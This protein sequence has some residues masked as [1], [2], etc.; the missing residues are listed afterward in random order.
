MHDGRG[1]ERTAA[2]GDASSANSNAGPPL[3]SAPSISLPKGGGAIRGIGEKFAA[4]PVTGTGSMTVPIAVTPGRSGF[5]PQ[6]TIS[7]DSGLGNGPLGFG[8]DLSLPA[9]TR[10][11]DKGLPKYHD[12]D[13][14]DTFI[15]TG[16]EDL[17]PLLIK[18]GNKWRPSLFERAVGSVIYRITRYCPRVEGLFARIEQWT[19]VE[20]GDTHWR[21]ISKE[22]ITT[23]YGKTPESR[24]ADPDDPARVFS[25]LICESRDDKGN[26]IVY[27]YV[28]EDSNNIDLAQ[29][30]ERNRTQ[31]SRSANRYLKRIK[32][33]NRVSLL[34][35]PDLSQAV[36][37]FEVVFD[38]DEGHYDAL[39]RRTNAQEF[40]RANI[41]STRNWS[42]RRDPFSTFRAGFEVRTYRLCRRALMFHHFSEELGVE[43]YLV[44]STEFH[45]AE[46]PIASFLTSVTQSGYVRHED[47]AYLIRSLPPLEFKYSEAVIQDEIRQVD[48][49]S[50]ENLPYGLESARYQWVDLDGEGVSGILTQQADEWFYKPNIG[51]GRFGPAQLV[52]LKPS[53]ADLN[54]AQQ[55]MDLD[56][57]GQL[58]L[59]QL[60]ASMS[61]FYERTPEGG[62][63]DFTPF[64]STPNLDWRDS[65][66]RFIDLTGDGNADILISG[67]KIFTWHPSLKEEGFGQGKRTHQSFDEEQGPRLVFADPAQSI[68]L[69]D[70]SGDGLTDLVRVRN[71]EV[72]YWPNLGYG[73]FGARI[74]MDDS[75]WLDAPGL[76]DQRRIRLA[77]IDGS[78]VTDIVYL[79]TDGVQIYFNQSGNGWTEQRML[80]QFPRIDNLSTVTIVDL[81][82]NGTACL[83]WSSP[84]PGDVRRPMHYIDLMGG[85]KPHLMV[86][87]KNNLGAETR[88]HYVAST[89][90][91][92]AD[93]A[94]GKPW[95]TKLPFPVHVV[96]RVETLDQI[97]RNRFVTR[98]AYHHGFFDG[99]EREFRGFGMV[100]QKDTE[101][102]ASLSAGDN[103]LNATNVDAASHVPPVLTKTWFHTGVWMEGTR[104]L[105]QFEREYYREPGLSYAELDALLLPDTILPDGLSMQEKREACRALRGS[106]LRQEIYALDGA[107]H[108]AHPHV[109]SERNYTIERLQPLADNR[110]A[111][112]FTHQ[113]ETIDYHYER[114]P[115]DPRTSHA[116]TL[117]VDAFGN[118][119][120]SAAVGYGRRHPDS[121]LAPQ[122]QVKQAQTLVTCAENKFT[123]AVEQDDDYRA[124]LPSER[125]TF[126]LTGLKSDSSVRFDFGIIDDAALSA[127]QIDYE[128]KPSDGL[129]KRLIEHIRTLY[130]RSDLDGPLPLG[131]L[132]SLA[133]PFESYRL[134]FTPGLLRQVYEECVTEEM[135]ASEGRYVHSEGDDNWWIPSGRAFFTL[136][137]TAPPAQ[138]LDDAR[139]HFFLPRLFLD[140]F[141]SATTVSYDTYDLLLTETRDA[142]G[143][144]VRSENDYRVMQPRLITDPNGN[145]AAVA[146]DALG[147]VVGTAVMGKENENLGDS[148]DGFDAD[149]DEATVKAHLQDP[150]ADP[151]DILKRAS[152]RLVYDLHL[153]QRTGSASN[154]QPSVVYT[155]A[156]ETHDADLQPGEQTKV[157]HSFS[158]S[159]GFGREI[160][161]KIQAEPGPVVEGEPE[162]APRWVGSGWTIFNNK[163]KPV[164]QYE[165]FFSAT[166]Q[167]EFARRV[168]VSSI[169]FYD[170][171]ERV[172]GTLHPN[173]TWEK[174][175]FDPWRQEMWDVNDT[176][177]VADPKSDPDVGDFFSHLPDPDFL[178]T[179]YAQRK[180]GA[181]G[182]LE[183]AA[184]RKA[185]V[186]ANSP[187]V[188]HADAL[189]RT[190]LTVVHNKFKYNDAH[191][192][193]PP[194]EEF[195]CTRVLLDIENNEREVIDAKDR[196]VM[197]YDYDLLGNR[198]H[199]ASMEAGERWMLNDVAGKPIHAWD[200]RN[201]QF[202]TTYDQLRRPID[203]LLR[204][205]SGDELLVGRSV[206]GESRPDPEASNLR[207]KVVQVFDQ[208]GVITSDEYDFKGNLLHG[209]RQLASDYKTVLDWS[210][211]VPLE[212]D[213]YTSRTRYDA[214][215]RPTEMTTPDK[216]V[217]RPGYN[218]ANLLERVEAN[219]RGEQDKGEPVWTPFV[220]DIDYDAKGQRTLIDYGNG[221]RITYAYDPLTFRLV[222]LLTR[223][224]AEAFPDDCPQPPP[225]NWPGCQVQNLHY[226]Y[227]PV[228]NITN[229]RDDA[230]QTVFF[231]NKRVEPSADYTYDALNRLIEATGREHLGQV[232]AAVSP[233]SYN[234]K[235]RVGILFS[236]S[237]G[238]AM[239]RYLERYVYDEV[240]NFKEMIHRGSDP[241]NAGWTRAYEYDEPSLLEPAKQGNRLTGTIVGATT[242]TYSVGGNGY[243]AHGNMLRMP[244]LQIMQWDFK[245]QLQM[246][247]RQAVNA[248]EEE[249]ARRQGERTWY[250]Y[251]ANGQRVRKV[252]ESAAGQIKDERIYLGGFEIYR[253]PGA[254]AL[255]RETL[256]IMDDRQRIAIVETRT[257]GNDDLPARLIRFQF[258]NH[259][260]SA[261]LEL[262]EHAQIISYEE[263]TP[264]GSTGYQAVRSQ[265][266]TP[267]RY[268][269]TGKERDEES[270]Y[271]YIGARYYCPWL[272]RWTRP[273]PAGTQDGPC[274]YAYVQNNPVRRVDPDGR[275]GYDTQE[276]MRGMMWER[277]SREIS[278]IITGMFGGSADVDV[279][280]NRVEYSGP[281]GGV[282][283]VVGGVVRA[284]TLRMV[285]IEDH[286]TMT[287]LMGLEVGAGLVPVLDP[288]ARL[289]TGESVTGQETS[290][291]WAAAQLALDVAPFLWELH[292]ARIEARILA[293]EGR[294]TSVSLAF[295]PGAPGHNRVGVNTGEGTQWSHLVVDNSRESL[296]VIKGG[297]AF[298]EIP[299]TPLGSKYTVVEIPVSPDS[300]ARAMANAQAQV[301]AGE[302]GAYGLLSNDCSTYASNILQSG[303]VRMPPVSTPALNYAAVALRSPALVGPLHVAAAVGPVASAGLRTTYLEEQ[304]QASIPEEHAACEMSEEDLLRVCLPDA[305]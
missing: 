36:W 66:L 235:Q 124:P 2:A 103:L 100:E 244:H 121:S 9:I 230:Q 52:S 302:A 1:E 163:G 248:D 111:V 262:D 253:K 223:R 108:S 174:V 211:E 57:D 263:Y 80:S 280:Q 77:D 119:L 232:G 67:D 96:E 239:G 50:L 128:A 199:Q 95:I 115:A 34:T 40:A 243:D 60:S 257:Q 282:G 22:N 251:D 146:F 126:E 195:Y 295:R 51:G 154:P 167:F 61:G 45:Y 143:N 274:L 290:R 106:I 301:A 56:G 21:S 285:P 10:K 269:Y 44:R 130:R 104:V 188:T 127:A 153:Y 114:N 75:P 98:Y 105:R 141:G 160:Q 83:V 43:D 28:P 131:Q 26:A 298:V 4:N 6:L 20:T 256:H 245:D 181:L 25:W 261:S 38:Y 268:R 191:P 200:S 271:Y 179:W 19:N 196:V 186:N 32:Y 129:Q 266:E 137:E 48:T 210:A 31:Q 151:L 29:A 162:V 63:S 189:G 277:M 231:R 168:G 11:T 156:R 279:A 69:A 215:N 260:G 303:G 240:G 293:A 221:V 206:Y 205:S 178:P 187:A 5:S 157:Q 84:L 297:D 76:F 252:T 133:L 89:E 107:P 291:G 202:R 118:V 79:G 47:G 90:F 182:Q 112:F 213:T 59:V 204:E 140:P 37:L 250:A 49:D 55:L 224:S 125:R 27:E 110:F 33:G 149:L 54:G 35:N 212:A 278:G 177:L 237:D 216:S 88:V 227:D 136:N 41:N 288:G 144:T 7:Y 158:Y 300:A 283:G 91:Y 299:D 8:W 272:A 101:E 152:T 203:S 193:D 287:S 18:D 185:A 142:L 233:S 208:A 264:Y 117:E 53:I 116:L 161:K 296:G 164:R 82:G 71:G 254:D 165:P 145:R 139:Q 134:A 74:T 176:V 94:A 97:S 159:D 123:N 68:F 197:R 72:C 81:L 166:H 155:M 113:R 225:T 62:W 194:A 120:R 255:V 70:M 276:M 207:G 292:A 273:D 46:T 109:V 85:Q 220:T 247:Q 286:P 275:Q 294:G 99:T 258:S 24:V 241:A 218:E 15:L 39:S 284:G 148:L 147:I 170:P 93:K 249:G 87:V 14:S 267:K 238:Q 183:E 222:R 169:L 219:L 135:L 173:H 65:N 289:V 58:D 16:A 138:E 30:H 234:D 13:E 42:V 305:Q 270:G 92:L 246:T 122:D 78:G 64:N 180:T 259:L 73:R 281:Q 132:E 192:D 171:V 201:H 265:T 17:V 229:I 190:F 150:F 214:L 198:I 184:A 12:A 102:F 228:G 304:L 172:V 175:I 3:N 242:E 226:V 209:H 236:A 217:I 23:F 86:E